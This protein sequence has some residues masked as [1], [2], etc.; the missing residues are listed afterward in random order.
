MGSLGSSQ[1][2]PKI[3]NSIVGAERTEGHA[4]GLG[5]DTGAQLRSNW[6]QSLRHL[7]GEQRGRWADSRWERQDTGH[8]S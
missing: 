6:H 7:A 5:G 1:K 4:D 3:E 8:G 2:M